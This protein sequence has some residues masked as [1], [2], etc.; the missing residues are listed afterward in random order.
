MTTELAEVVHH[1]RNNS[2]DLVLRFPSGTL[3]RRLSSYHQYTA[4]GFPLPDVTYS[5]VFLPSQDQYNNTPWTAILPV[6]EITDYPFCDTQE[7]SVRFIKA[8]VFELMKRAGATNSSQ[9]VCR[10][11]LMMDNP[12]MT[13]PDFLLATLLGLDDHSYLSGSSEL[14]FCITYNR[15][16]PGSELND[17]LISVTLGVPGSTHKFKI[18]AS[19]QNNAVCLECLACSPTRPLQL[20]DMQEAS[21]DFQ[22]NCIRVINTDAP[23]C[24]K[25]YHYGASKTHIGQ[26]QVKDFAAMI[27]K[28][29][30]MSMKTKNRLDAV[31]MGGHKRLG[32]NSGFCHLN[33]DLLGSIACMTLS[34]APYIVQRVKQQFGM[35]FPWGA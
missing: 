20:Q 19:I 22:T 30:S 17:E 16:H 5:I 7:K 12:A 8:E 6:I 25:A 31:F 11:I 32:A 27:V 2:H 35:S 15:S 34:P 4:D 21:D 10:P 33:E 13:V 3:E 14:A 9:S 18:E 26:M 28:Q 29:Y 1:L 24:Y 23:G